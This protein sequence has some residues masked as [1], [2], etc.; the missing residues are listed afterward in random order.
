M[1]GSDSATMRINRPI[2]DDE[3]EGISS[4]MFTSEL[5]FLISMGVRNLVV[6]INS[7]GGNMFQGLEIYSALQDSGIN[8]ETRVVG[9]AASISGVISQA[10][11]KRCIKKHAVFHAHSPR[12]E[13][14]STVSDKILDISFQS[15][16]SIMVEN[17]KMSEDQVDKMLS[18]ESFF[19]SEEAFNS[20]FFDEIMQSERALENKIKK[21]MK[22]EEIMN[23]VNSIEVQSKNKNMSK[24]NEILGLQNEAS[25]SVVIDKVTELQANASKVATLEAENTQ[26][27]AKV[28]ET[29]RVNATNMIEAAAKE[30][31]I[32]ISDEA[33]KT[34]LVEAAIKNPEGTKSMLDSIVSVS[35]AQHI[36]TDDASGSAEN[37][38]DW[39]F[40]KWSK[41]DPEGLLAIKNSTPE[42]YEN[43]LNA[44]V[45]SK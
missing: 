42:K 40:E 25:E 28:E 1:N 17:S 15:L 32:D 44:Y 35:A 34:A 23:L 31:K 43:M 20:G 33:K 10:G 37:R 45:E 16:K 14:G 9:I 27:K 2:S 4:R 21:S 39:G 6:T 38:K 18:T 13:E 22:P 26:L 41:E 7:P 30:G 36:K 24:V 12:A 11:N 29:E 19:T 3:N 5:D 8:V